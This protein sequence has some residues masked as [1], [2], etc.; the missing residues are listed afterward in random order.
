V[1]RKLRTEKRS[2]ASVATQFTLVQDMTSKAYVFT[3]HR[4]EPDIK[5]CRTTILS[6]KYNFVNRTVENSII[7][8]VFEIAGTQPSHRVGTSSSNPMPTPPKQKT[9]LK[10]RF[11][12]L[13]RVDKKDAN[14][15][16][17]NQ[18]DLKLYIGFII[19]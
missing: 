8:D 4:L 18:Q 14:E 16:F 19:S 2:F 17:G 15:M 13:S 11:F 1:R 9:D 3:K 10:G 5:L 6:Q 7:I 12:V